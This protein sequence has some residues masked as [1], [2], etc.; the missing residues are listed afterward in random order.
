MLSNL[1]PSNNHG[2][3]SATAGAI[4]DTP[5]SNVFP[6]RLQESLPTTCIHDELAWRLEMVVGWGQIAKNVPPKGLLFTR[7]HWDNLQVHT[8]R[9]G[10]EEG[11]IDDTVRSVRIAARDYFYLVAKTRDGCYNHRPWAVVDSALSDNL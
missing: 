9:R 1:D 5:S 7:I 4:F 8:F 10:A 3:L 2:R 6:V 11:A